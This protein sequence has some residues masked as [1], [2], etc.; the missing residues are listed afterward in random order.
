MDN[1]EGRVCQVC[2]NALLR[3]NQIIIFQ[4]VQSFAQC[5]VP[6]NIHAHTMEGYRKCQGG[7]VSQKQKL[8]KKNTV[9]EPKLEFLEGG[10]RGVW[11]K[12]KK[13][14]L[15]GVMMFSGTTQFKK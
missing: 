9:H 4:G 8:L 5:V 1:K 6:G 2:C 3:G 15:R 12:S 14:S 10:G 7:G 11:V 13:P